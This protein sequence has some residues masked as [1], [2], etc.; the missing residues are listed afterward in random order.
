MPSNTTEWIAIHNT[1]GLVVFGHSSN[2]SDVN[3]SGGQEERITQSKI[4]KMIEKNGY[5]LAKAYMLQCYSASESNHE[6]WLKRTMQ[7]HDYKGMN[8]L[9]ID[10]GFFSN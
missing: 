6:E 3:Y 10:F 1:W 9:Y 8:A 7:L 5:K 2:K 4:R